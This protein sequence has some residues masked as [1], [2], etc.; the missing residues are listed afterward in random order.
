MLSILKNKISG[1]GSGELLKVF[2]FTGLSML[3]KLCTSFLM[4]KVV[5]SIIGPAGTALVGQLQNFIAIFTSVGSGGINNGVVKFVSEFREDTDQLNYSIS[6]GFLLTLF[7][8]TLAGL[9]SAVFCM[10][11]SEWILNDSSY[12]YLFI[13]FGFS[14]ILVS[15]NNFFLSVVN[16]FTQYRKY[17]IISMITS[18]MGL[19]LT[20]L[21]AVFY[22][23]PGV[24][25]SLV[26]YQGIMLFA[27]LF[28][29]RKEKWLSSQL[30]KTIK[31]KNT[32]KYFAYTAMAFVT[33]LTVPVA[34]LL[35]RSYIID[36][37]SLTVAG[38]WES[39]N[40]ISAM[41]LL[42]ITSSFSVYY[43]PKLSQTH[44]P[45]KLKSEI[46]KTYTV[47]LP[48][49]AVALVA[50]F[51]FREL[52]I[53]LVFTEEFLPMEPL[54]QWQ[55]LGDF[56]KISS[57]LL[58]FIMVAKSMTKPYIIT[59]IVFAAIMVGT[60][61]FFV[62]KNGVIGATQAYCLTYFLYCVVMVVLFR[63]LLFSA[64]S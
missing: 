14:L 60:S 3:V 56:F 64:S 57:W 40:K 25:I 29:L 8:A 31:R 22:E 38:F 7:F 15:L 13:I 4:V 63:K 24:M 47:M 43:L 36:E 34:Q 28:I 26:S 9:V 19:I 6:T 48:V 50:I 18:V 51:L 49:T 5:A 37:Y 42:F 58:A 1:S 21:L 27:T 46:L 10:P 2:S 20:V 11:L 32:E 55:L 52:V 17:V 35:I 54:F 44:A 12:Y 59:E 30:W 39:V 62:D 45:D 61:V 16:G 41:F 33:A 53:R 23:L